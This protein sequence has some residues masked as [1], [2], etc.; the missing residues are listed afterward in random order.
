MRNPLRIFMIYDYHDAFPGTYSSYFFPVTNYKTTIKTIIKQ[1]PYA[2]ITRSR[3]QKWTMMRACFII[4]SSRFVYSLRCVFTSPCYTFY[5]VIVISKFNL[6]MYVLNLYSNIDDFECINYLA[7][8]RID[9][10]YTDWVVIWARCKYCP[11]WMNSNH[12]NPFTVPSVG[13]YTVSIPRNILRDE[14]DFCCKWF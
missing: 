14:H 6:Q 9:V 12:S 5:C 13:F 8:F 11:I 7:L 4:S 10:P 1:Y 2:F 3:S